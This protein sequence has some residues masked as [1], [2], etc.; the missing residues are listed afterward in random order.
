MLRTEDRAGLYITIIIHLLII[1]ILLLS[2]ISSSRQSENSFVLDFTKQEEIERQQ[3]EEAEKQAKLEKIEA[4]REQMH[5]NIQKELSNVSKN[6]AVDR[7]A[8]LKDDRGTDSRKLYEDAKKLEEEL[9]KGFTPTPGKKDDGELAASDKAS[10]QQGDNTPEPRAQ[11]SGASVT[12]WQL[13]GRRAVSLPTPSYKCYGGGSVTVLIVVD[14]AGRVIE[15]SVQG[16]SPDKCLRSNA[17]A[18][19]K[20]SRFNPT[21]DPS[22]PEKQTGNIVYEFIA[23]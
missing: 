19:A 8:P 5:K 22:I 14:R 20:R 7:N 1:V 4:V 17:V 11:Y 6:I 16:G 21:D 15:A 10:E 12:S 13:D 3:K 9:K 2:Q 18:F 23:Q